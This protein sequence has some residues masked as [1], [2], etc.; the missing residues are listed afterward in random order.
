MQPIQPIIG[1]GI[2]F[3]LGGTKLCSDD[4][5][6]DSICILERKKHLKM[7]KELRRDAAATAATAAATIYK[8]CSCS[9]KSWGAMVPGP[10]SY[11]Y[12]YDNYL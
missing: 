3:L 8:Y 6:T 7:N 10:R 11:A 5:N 4:I 12:A 1:V 2:V 9:H